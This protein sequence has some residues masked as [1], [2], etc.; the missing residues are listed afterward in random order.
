MADVRF[1]RIGQIVVFRLDRLGRSLLHIA[2]ITAV[3]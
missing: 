1:G 2:Q 3:G